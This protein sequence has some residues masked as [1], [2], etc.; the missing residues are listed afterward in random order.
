M[1][2]TV[3][4]F[5]RYIVEL[6]MQR[7]APATESERMEFL[8]GTLEML[9]LRTLLAQKQHGYGIAQS[10]RHLSDEAFQ[11][12]AGSLYPAL[13]RLE[14]QD[15]ISGQWGLSD[16]GRRVRLYVLTSAGRRKLSMRMSGWDEFVAAVARVLHPVKATE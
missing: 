5:A 3:A 2:L 4:A 15:L 1:G 8:Q 9:I 16:T 7:K 10:I 13:Q 11:V 14:L 12:E 6:S